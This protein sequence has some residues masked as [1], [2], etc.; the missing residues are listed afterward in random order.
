MTNGSK[1][2]E[3]LSDQVYQVSPKSAAVNTLIEVDSIFGEDDTPA[4]SPRKQQADYLLYLYFNL[5]ERIG[6]SSWLSR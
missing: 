2:V 3:S 6:R 4:D 1:V 5:F